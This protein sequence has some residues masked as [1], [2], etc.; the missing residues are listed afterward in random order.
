MSRKINGIKIECV[1]GDI[2][3][4]NDA[5]AVVNAANACLM[6]GGGVAGAIHRA[7]GSSLAEECRSMAPLKPGE[8]VISGGYNL[9]NR[10]VIHCL[11]PVYGVDKPE[12]KLLSECYRRALLLADKNEI[13]TIAFPAISTGA[14][15]YPAEEAAEIAMKTVVDAARELNNLKKIRFVLHGEKAL[16]I[17]RK[18]LNSIFEKQ[19][20]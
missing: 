18:T 2:A 12:D 15:G 16:D 8:A 19:N 3:F 5:D 7:A 13:R 20:T 11:G 6:P 17:H 9:P 10:Y 4:Q 1:S 14:F